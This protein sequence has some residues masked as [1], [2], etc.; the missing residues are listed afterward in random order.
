MSKNI[1]SLRGDLE[2]SLRELMAA[3]PSAEIAR[4]R[5]V[6]K[7]AVRSGDLWSLV[8]E[9]DVL[10]SSWDRADVLLREK[11]RLIASTVN[12]LFS[13]FLKEAKK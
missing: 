7:E 12:N 8:E 2:S 9:V 11:P 6:K 3:I 13:E 1:D 5:E 10:L 4:L